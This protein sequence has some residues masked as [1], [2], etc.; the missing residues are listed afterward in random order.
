MKVIAE[1]EQAKKALTKELEEVKST[2]SQTEE[3]LSTVKEQKKIYYDLMKK[4]ATSLMS[5]VKGLMEV[6]NEVPNEVQSVSK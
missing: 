6:L 4:S 3:T 1:L 2:L 5:T